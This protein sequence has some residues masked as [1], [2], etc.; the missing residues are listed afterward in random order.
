[1]ADTPAETPKRRRAVKSPAEPKTPRRRTAATKAA[2]VEAPAAAAHS[3]AAP[4]KPGRKP[5]AKAADPTPAPTT[6]APAKRG[7]KPRVAAAAA[8]ATP[9]AVA[10]A[11]AEPARKPRT[12]KRTATAEKPKRQ[13]RKR[14]TPSPT[15][16]PAAV[17]AVAAPVRK[18]VERAREALPEAPPK[19]G[20]FAALGTLAALGGAFFLWRSSRAEEPD[21]QVLE[22][23]GA[24][25]IRRYPQLVTAG[26]EQRGQRTQALNDGFRVLA[27]YIFAKSR[28]GE[29][30]PMTAPVLSDSDGGGS[31]RTRFVMPTGK[32]RAALPTPPSGV[33]LV[34]EPSRRVAAIRFSGRADDETLETKEN[35]LR[36]WLQTRSLPHEG[37]AVHA[38][39]NAPFLP[40]PL[41]RNE[42][43]IVLSEDGGTG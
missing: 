21:Y 2:E 43:I 41:R 1:M 5:R 34:S 10:S 26:T 24:V 28:A 25:E 30:L 9:T 12:T 13:T 11:P 38:F 31:W 37:R 14:A 8:E 19:A 7:R 39:Y 36:S 6:T 40:G 42:V 29:K 35:A 23:D 17:A 20:V 3:P 32:A 4:S 16:A 27:D 22:S 33:D 18:A 15:P